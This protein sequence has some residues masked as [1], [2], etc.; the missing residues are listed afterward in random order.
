ML[1]QRTFESL[2]VPLAEVTFCVVDLETTGG[3]P[4]DDAITEVGA[5][6]VRCG[7]VE[8]TFQTL[9]DPGRRVPAFIRLLTGISDEMLTG[10]PA[11]GGVLPSFLEFAHNTVLVAH[12]ARFDVSFLNQALERH[13]YPA[14]DH[15]V[16]DTAG[17][18][19]KVLAGEVSNRKLETLARH[20]R[21]SHRPSHRAF[22]DALATVDVLHGLIE[23]VAGFGV[24]TLEDLVAMSYTKMDGTWRK[25]SLADRLP[26]GIGVY[27][28]LGAGDATLYVG[29]AADVR[30]R[31][32]SYFYGDAR[33][34]MR[35]LVREVQQVVAERHPNMLE[36]E[37]AEARA[38]A[39]EIPPY[40]RIGKRG[41]A[42]YLK[43]TTGSSRPRVHA[44]RVPK[45][46]AATY[47][48]PFPSC[49]L[50]RELIHH[51]RRS[52]PLEVAESIDRRP[53][54]VLAPLAK[55]LERLAREERFEEAAE[56][57]RA[58]EVLERE[59]WRRAQIGALLASKEIAL[60]VGSRAL[61]V[62][63]G[64]LAAALDI[65]PGEEETAPARLR[66]RARVAPVGSFLTPAVYREARLIARWLDRHADS[67]K[68]L[69]V[70]G[71]WAI[72]V[73]FRPRGRFAVRNR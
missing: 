34:R 55:R 22:E 57:R 52:A 25:V 48:G 1:V 5:V 58:A 43:V 69:S 31:V 12:N 8:G 56:L 17:L 66:A 71:T 33:R 45:E 37:V 68:L 9:V 15:R 36:A 3:S 59:L 29:K 47:L 38:I 53:E 61:L 27:R 42:W 28:F 19:R 2:G 14:L 60:A 32:R 35:D 41:G 6:K 10:A 30:S 11:I 70:S 16:V 64:Q 54:V 49:K 51:T 24:T 62:A 46:D 13:G 39:R 23:R 65:G 50:V 4:Y 73:A 21:C 18:A 20:L 72:P 7:E 40:N 26:H 44:A 63:G 67:V